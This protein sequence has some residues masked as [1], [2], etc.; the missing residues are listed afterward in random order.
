M[1]MTLLME[2]DR[3]NY[4]PSLPVISRRAVRAIIYKNEV[5]TMVRSEKIGEYKFPGGG[6]KNGESDLEA[7]ARELREETGL[8]LEPESV[9]P[10]GY[11]TERRLDRN[12]HS[13]YQHISCF[14]TCASKGLPEKTD[15]SP[16]ELSFGYHLEYTTIDNAILV[17]ERLL[18][19]SL[20]PW[21]E[22]ELFVL[23]DIRRRFPGQ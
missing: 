6:V 2:F 11:T 14:F 19:E 21:V 17:N 22:R 1:H 3:R 15:L 7:L 9:A 20:A 5:L 23:R 18:K 10:Y 13:I 4:D 16:R 8:A 12:G